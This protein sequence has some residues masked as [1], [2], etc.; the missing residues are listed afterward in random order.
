[1][2]CVDSMDL[3]AG[4][5]HSLELVAGAR[6]IKPTGRGDIENALVGGSNRKRAHDSG[7]AEVHFDQAVAGDTRDPAFRP[8]PNRAT[9][10][11]VYGVDVLFGE[12]CLKAKAKKLGTVVAEQAGPGTN[13]QKSRI[14]LRESANERTAEPL[15]LAI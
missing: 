9:V 7:C 4:R 3:R 10:R 11:H 2:S 15:L 13:P 8:H 12:A 14:V 5:V 1:G 6:R